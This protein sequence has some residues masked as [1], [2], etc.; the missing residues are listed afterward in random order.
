M[1]RLSSRLKRREW[2][3]VLASMAEH[4]P[5]SSGNH[6][7]LYTSAD[8][9]LADVHNAI[10]AAHQRVWMETYVFDG[11]PAAERTAGKLAAAA[12]RGVD[13]RLL[14][15]WLGSY[16]MP[17]G[18]LKDL[19]HAGVDVVMFN[20]LA[21][22]RGRAAIAFSFMKQML[23]PHKAAGNPARY[24]AC[25]HCHTKSRL[26]PLPLTFRN[27][28]KTLVADAAGFCGSMNIASEAFS[29]TAG[30]S[31]TNT[32]AGLRVVGPVTAQLEEALKES[33]GLAGVQLPAG[34]TDQP[35]ALDP[36]YGKVFKDVRLQLLTNNPHAHRRCIT[37]V[38][39]IAV[40]NAASSV[41]VTT[42]YFSPP[43]FLKKALVAAAARG[44]PT[45]LYLSGGS[46]VLGDS[47]GTLFQIQKTYMRFRNVQAFFSVAKHCHSK[48]TTVDGR[49]AMI[50]SNN[51]DRISA[52]RNLEAAVAIDDA[53][54]ASCL[55][56]HMDTLC[57]CPLASRVGWSPGL[58]GRSGTLTSV[59]WDA[60]SWRQ[61]SYKSRL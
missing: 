58:Y 9:C 59:Q 26:L 1:D 6:V 47:L 54:V 61:L 30:G 20:S 13:V 22:N 46:D 33:F 31:G 7:T 37:K 35:L 18:L 14:C 42:S 57:D 38:L 10:D 19:K 28:R 43:F 8:E 12:R 21:S 50:G 27:H 44:V 48:W 5:F 51:W 3:S 49:W 2:R 4:S 40:R 11:S 24:L 17:E 23:F 56:S 15:D 25:D 39:E 45:S 53:R 41:R 60:A 36:A 29:P 16:R 32:E 55:N 34:P 52:K